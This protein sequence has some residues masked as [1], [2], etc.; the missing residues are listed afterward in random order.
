MTLETFRGKANLMFRLKLLR[1]FVNLFSTKVAVVE[2][3]VRKA[4]VSSVDEAVGNIIETL[5]ATGTVQGHLAIVHDTLPKKIT[6][7]LH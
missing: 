1:L 4:M 3:V 7:T 2:Q 6:I 5:E